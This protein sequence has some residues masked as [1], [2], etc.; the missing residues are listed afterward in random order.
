M[1]NGIILPGFALRRGTWISVP[2]INALAPWED[3]NRVPGDVHWPALAVVDQLCEYH[4]GH[5]WLDVIVCSEWPD[6]HLLVDAATVTLLGA[7]GG[8]TD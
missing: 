3:P 6:R 2:G 4:A 8:E 1:A 5:L 7:E